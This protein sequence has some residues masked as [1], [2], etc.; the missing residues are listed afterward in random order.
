MKLPELIYVSVEPDRDGDP[1]FSAGVVETEVIDG[2]GPTEVGTYRLV[3]KRR[4][5]KAVREKSRK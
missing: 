5:E 3:K 2:D 1:M 4:L